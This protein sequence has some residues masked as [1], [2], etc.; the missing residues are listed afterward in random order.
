VRVPWGISSLSTG[1]CWL[2]VSSWSSNINAE[3]EETYCVRELICI[4]AIS[5]TIQIIDIIYMN[6]KSDIIQ[7]NSYNMF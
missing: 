7:N 2:L 6:K 5:D 4:S 1:L 3:K